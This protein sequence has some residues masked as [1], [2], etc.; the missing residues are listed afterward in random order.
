MIG[1]T[2]TTTL[3]HDYIDSE[4]TTEMELFQAEFL[5]TLNPPGMPQH[6]L[7]S[8]I[9]CPI[10][11]LRN[12]D[13]ISGLCNG[14][15]LTVLD[16]TEHI[17]KAKIASGRRRGNTV[18]IPKIKL[19]YSG[20]DL[21]FRLCRVQF[22]VSLAFAMTINKAQGQT[23]SKI[24]LYFAENLFSHGQLYVAFS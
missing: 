9:G 22:P 4:D 11:L 19:T 15:R 5:N 10:I 17:I 16:V 1:G 23:F 14:T 2:Q 3:S 24:G 6:Q 18:L 8:S 21:P 20:V 7:V 13:S 12:L